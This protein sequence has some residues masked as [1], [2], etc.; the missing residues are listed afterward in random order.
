M[1]RP[2]SIATLALDLART[3]ANARPSWVRVETWEALRGASAAILADVRA[4]VAVEGVRGSAAVLGVHV[5]TVVRA[6]S[7]GAL[8]PK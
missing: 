5:A 7:S 1:R 2:A 4:V 3:L 8:A 6:R